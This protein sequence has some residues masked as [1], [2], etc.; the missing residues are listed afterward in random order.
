[1]V[2]GLVDEVGP[3]TPVTVLV[4]NFFSIVEEDAPFLELPVDKPALALKELDTVEFLP[5]PTATFLGALG[6]TLISS[7]LLR[8]MPT[9]RLLLASLLAVVPFPKDLSLSLVRSDKEEANKAAFCFSCF[10]LAFSSLSL[11]DRSLA[12]FDIA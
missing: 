2:F 4:V 5:S 8:L 11:A 1:M 9:L 6:P 12:L 10:S 3:L 7:S